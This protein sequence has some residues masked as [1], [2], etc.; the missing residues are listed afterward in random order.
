MSTPRT[1]L[2]GLA[3]GES[4]RWYDGRIWLSDMGANEVVAVGLDGRRD[5]VIPVPAIPMGLGRSPDGTLLIF[6]TV[7]EW[8]DDGGPAAEGPR[9][10][11]VHLVDAPAAAAGWP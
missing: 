2:T 4:P 6:M 3:M 9:T 5:V 1:L 8:S 10:G 11:Q 7:A